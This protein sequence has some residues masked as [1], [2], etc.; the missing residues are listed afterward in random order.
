MVSHLLNVVANYVKS[1]AILHDGT[2]RAGPA[3][4]IL[5]DAALSELYGIPIKVSEV[6]GQKI[7]LA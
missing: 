4:E 7:V 5:T 2:L 6:D 1:L 3:E